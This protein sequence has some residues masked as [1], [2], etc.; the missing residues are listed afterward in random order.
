MNILPA[1]RQ[2]RHQLGQIHGAPAAKS[3]D[4]IRLEAL[5]QPQSGFEIGDVRLGL[6]LAEHRYLARQA[7]AFHARGVEAIRDHQAAP[8]AMARG[9]LRQRCQRPRAKGDL[10]GLQQ[11]DRRLQCDMLQ[12]HFKKIP[13]W[14]GRVLKAEAGA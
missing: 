5:G 6:H 4:E 9:K 1:A 7:Q 11:L 12:L 8:D 2:H 13:L 3:D 14:Y 10:G